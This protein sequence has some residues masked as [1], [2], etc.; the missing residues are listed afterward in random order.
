MTQ[1]D[2]FT[3][4][5]KYQQAC[6]N[7]IACMNISRHRF[8]F[9]YLR[10]SEKMGIIE[11]EIKEKAAKLNADCSIGKGKTTAMRELKRYVNEY[12][13]ILGGIYPGIL[14]KANI[15]K[16][17][18][19]EN[20]STDK[21]VGELYEE[22]IGDNCAYSLYSY[23]PKINKQKRADAYRAIRSQG[24]YLIPL[25]IMPDT[26]VFTWGYWHVVYLRALQ[27]SGA[28]LQ[29]LYNDL[30]IEIV[31]NLIILQGE[32]KKTYIEYISKFIE[33]SIYRIHSDNA[34]FI[35]TEPGYSEAHM[36]GIFTRSEFGVLSEQEYREVREQILRADTHDTIIDLQE[37]IK[38]Q[39][40]VD[41][42]IDTSNKSA[43]LPSLFNESYTLTQ[44]SSNNHMAFIESKLHPLSGLWITGGKIMTD[45][46]YERM[47][48]YVNQTFEKLALPPTIYPIACDYV[49]KWFLMHTIYLVFKKTTEQ[50]KTKA[51][52]WAQLLRS[53]FLSCSVMSVAYIKQHFSTDKDK[54]RQA[55]TLMEE[56]N[57]EN[58]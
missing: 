55:L 12:P 7:H 41:E 9:I 45:E 17:V 3:E 44:Q 36:C 23:S 14:S 22:L 31:S 13:E 24:L 37:L 26:T 21:L 16:G 2:L 28:I 35:E 6:I 33:K 53:L 54:Y 30:E 40:E 57:N 38:A 50:K 29:N 5:K 52:L 56:R 25:T 49:E 43:A 18:G 32:Q 15:I 19:K 1:I 46:E 20:C 58:I 34:N 48:S 8:Y 42:I 39:T 4:F 10:L 51:E 11:T 47:V 27:N